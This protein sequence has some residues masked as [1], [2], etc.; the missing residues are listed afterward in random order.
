MKPVFTNDAIVLGILMTVLALVF[1]TS[2]SKSKAWQKLYRFVPPLLLCYFIPALLHWPFGIIANDWYEPGLWDALRQL[3]LNPPEKATFAEIQQ[4]MAIHNV[5]PEISNPF[6]GE[7]GLYKV[8]SRFL[9]PASLILLCIGI[10]LKGIISLGP[11]ALIIFLTATT[12]I[13]LGG[14]LALLAVTTFFPNLIQISTDDL[15]RGLTTIAGS[16]IGGGGNQMAMRAIF[17]VP[18]NVF[19]TMVVVDIMVGNFWLALLL[20]GVGI[21]NKIDKFLKAD[22]RAID[23]LVVSARA[24]RAQTERMPTNKDIFSWLGLTFAG[25][26]IS[27]WGAG[28]ITSWLSKFQ[29]QLMAWRL[30]AINSTFF[31]IAVIATTFGLLASFTSARKLEGVGASRWGSIFLY[32]LVATIGMQMD[33]GAILH[34][35]GLFVIGIIWM[36]IHMILL[37]LVARLLRAPFF[38]VAVGSQANVGGAASAPIVA[39]AFDPALAPVGA[40]LAV[41]GYALGTY[42]ALVSA[43]LM[44]IIASGG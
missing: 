21:R 8:A 29:E 43:F 25:V 5:S 37:I 22:T 1:I 40:L 20:Y 44:K 19:G 26:A 41:L 18:Q 6:R 4:F 7:S 2:G 13:I 10:D 36:F 9:L 16:W 38:Y 33:L 30:D 24:F 3:G 39:S 35:M 34:N 14:P 12:G 27:H 42:G 32:F 15:W 28:V 11:K 17:E 23:E 31:W